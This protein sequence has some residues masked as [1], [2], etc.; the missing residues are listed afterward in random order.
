MTEAATETEESTLDWIWGAIQ[1]DFN[2]NPTIGQIITNAAITAIPL[3]D[4]VADGRDLV[5]NLKALIWDK[6]YNEM[7]VWVGLFFTLIGLIP[8]LGSLLKGVLK[9]IY[10][11]AKLDDVFRAFNALAKGNAWEWLKKLRAGELR[12]HA[13]EAARMLKQVFDNIIATLKEALSY[14]PSWAD[15][16]YKN[17]SDLI[18]EM[19]AIRDQI[20]EMFGKITAD[21]EA[22]LDDL[23][24]QQADNS[25]EGNSRQTLM[26]R[27]EADANAKPPRRLP[28]LPESMDE[29]MKRMDDATQKVQQARANSSPLP[30]SPYTLD[31]KL[32]IVEAGLEEKDIVGVI[33]S[34]HA[35]DSGN[36]GWVNPDTDR[37]NYW[38]TTYTQL[39]HADK[40]AELIAKAVGT[41]YDPKTDYTLLV[42]DAAAAAKQGDITTFI[43]TY[44]RIGGLAKSEMTD[45]DPKLID[46][47]MT[48]E[49]SERYA[50]LFEQAGE[51]GADLSDSDSLVDF[52]KSQGLSPKETELLK[53][54]QIINDK[55]GAN[56]QF[57][58]IGITKDVNSPDGLG[59]VETYS[60]DKKPGLLGDLEQSGVLKRVGL[61]SY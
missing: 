7:A 27:Q 30:Q 52:A 61:T 40:D 20:D 1:G 53:A 57:L 14:V 12:Q 23:L 39:E 16:L 8:S 6:R 46:Q 42:I 44:D 22:K 58:G 37:S 29:V 21:L 15:D 50:E 34:S 54:R 11:G 45:V 10:R 3:V 2:E 18:A 28:P 4:Q 9:L 35:K 26:M 19:R 55:Y 59:T 33:K 32:A 31:D 51:T 24:K 60:L 5:A 25:V 41:T 13:D 48:P 47:A 17:I 56:E 36:I 49:Y 38:T 43:P